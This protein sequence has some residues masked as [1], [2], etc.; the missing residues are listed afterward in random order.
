MNPTQFILPLERKI[1]ALRRKLLRLG[2]MHPGSVSRQYQVC[3]KPGCRCMHPKSPQRHGP[4]YKLGYVH[5]GQPVCR[6]VR[7]DCIGEVQ[8]R[9]ANYKIFRKIINALIALSI[10]RGQL[11]W[12]ARRQTTQ[13][14]TQTPLTGSPLQR[15]SPKSKPS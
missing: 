14:K 7:A 1:H 15:R 10:Q 3:G 9:L 5:R 2:P 11:D 13:K 4:Y 12:F 6:F 8:R